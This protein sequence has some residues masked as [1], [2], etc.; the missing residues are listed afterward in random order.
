MKQLL[1]RSSFCLLILDVSFNIISASYFLIKDILFTIS[2][3]KRLIKAI[4]CPKI[5]NS[6]ALSL[7]CIIIDYLSIYQNFNSYL[8]ILYIFCQVYNSILIMNDI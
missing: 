3:T 2:G 1:E 5:E 8:Y 7:Y 4:Y 6:Y